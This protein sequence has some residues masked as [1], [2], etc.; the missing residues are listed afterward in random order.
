MLRFEP[1]SGQTLNRRDLYRSGAGSCR[2]PAGEEERGLPA[3]AAGDYGGADLPSA[4]AGAGGAHR[5]D[6]SARLRC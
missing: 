1:L 2:A 5:A 4:V 6:L 3:P